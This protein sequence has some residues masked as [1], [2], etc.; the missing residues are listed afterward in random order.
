MFERLQSARND[1]WMKIFVQK[2]A[3]AKSFIIEKYEKIFCFHVHFKEK[4]PENVSKR[5]SS[6]SALMS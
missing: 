6:S 3:T 5:Y 2:Y 4:S 1:T